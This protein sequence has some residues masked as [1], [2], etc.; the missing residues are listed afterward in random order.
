[1]LCYPVYLY[2]TIQSLNVSISS[3]DWKSLVCSIGGIAL[4]SPERMPI[5]VV[6]EIM[7]FDEDSLACLLKSLEKAKEGTL[8]FP[9]VIETSDFYSFNSTAISKVHDIVLLL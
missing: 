5:L 8:H 7:N 1:M 3:G 4:C 9:V 6:R 2:E